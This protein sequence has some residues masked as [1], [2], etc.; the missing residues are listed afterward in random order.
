MAWHCGYTDAVNQPCPR[1]D[2]QYFID[3]IKSGKKTTW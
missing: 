1:E 2:K 3:M